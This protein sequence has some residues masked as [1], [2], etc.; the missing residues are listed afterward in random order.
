MFTG[1]VSGRGRVLAVEPGRLAIDAG[2]LAGRLEVG[3][4]IAVNGCCLTA[5]AVEGRRVSMDVV[6][7]TVSRTNLGRLAPD[8]EVNL[9][10]PM[11]LS[12]GLD[13]HLV[14]GHID[15]A[16]KVRSVAPVAQGREL[17]VELPEDLAPYVVEKGSIAVDGVSL[18]VAA[19]GL[20]SFT[21]ALIPHTL[22]HTIA[23][24][25]R[26]GSVVNIEVDL[27]ARYV[28]RLLNQRG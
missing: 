20:G 5:T 7:E 24:G 18:T 2:D 25:Y 26:E 15:A 22:K 3:G 11:S 6:P 14:Q 21:I 27:I 13:G 1:I 12:A 10:L 4:S 23:G 28:E 8:D 16:V 19:L 9:E 17:V